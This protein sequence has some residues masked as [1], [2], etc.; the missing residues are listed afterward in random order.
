MTGLLP[1]RVLVIDPGHGSVWLD[2]VRYEGDYV[3]GEAWDDS[4]RGS[5]LMPDDYSGE[6]ITLNF[7]R[8]LILRCEP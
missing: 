1:R 4:A 2:N 7:P 5:A 6:P 3:I 8:S